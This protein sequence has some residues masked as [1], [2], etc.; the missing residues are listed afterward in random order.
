MTHRMKCLASLLAAAAL[1]AAC[2]RRSETP[3]T[4][5]AET[6]AEEARQQGCLG[7]DVATHS[8]GRLA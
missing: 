5:A 7:S 8:W 4:A 6:K 1:A 3:A 2:G